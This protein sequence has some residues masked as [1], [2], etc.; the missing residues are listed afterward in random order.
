MAFAQ[1]IAFQIGHPY[2]SGAYE[3]EVSESGVAGVSIVAGVHFC[4]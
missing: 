4:G 1:E 3:K 2:A